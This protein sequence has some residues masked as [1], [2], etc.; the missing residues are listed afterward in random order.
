[1]QYAYLLLGQH[2]KSLS[3]FHLHN[4]I[5]TKVVTLV[6]APICWRSLSSILCHRFGLY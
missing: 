5:F 6:T 2:F 1:M 4:H 3:I